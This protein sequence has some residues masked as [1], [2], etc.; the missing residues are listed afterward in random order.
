M[1]R[2]ASLRTCL[3]L[4]MRGRIVFAYV[5]MLVCSVGIVVTILPS[6]YTRVFVAKLN[7]TSFANASLCNTP[8]QRDS[9][10][11]RE[12]SALAGSWSGYTSGGSA[13]VT[14][15]LAPL[16]GQM[17]D[18]Y[19][20]RR[21][22]VAG[23]VLALLPYLV[24]GLGINVFHFNAL[25][26]VY[27]NYSLQIIGGGVSN[28]NLA[29]ALMWI[30][31]NFEKAQRAPAFAII[32]ASVDLVLA[33][34]PILGVL[35]NRIS[36][37]APWYMNAL[38]FVLAVMLAV[39][40]PDSPRFRPI[41]V[42]KENIGR[43][44]SKPKRR[45]NDN[46][47]AMENVVEPLLSE[48]CELRSPESQRRFLEAREKMDACWSCQDCR[49]V[50]PFQSLSI[51]N[52][53]VFFRRL[54]T[55]S[56]FNSFVNS[57]LQSI[58]FYML[59]SAL[60]MSSI[61]ISTILAIQA[62]CGFL[63]QAFLVRPLIRCVGLRRLVQFGSFC[64]I[65]LC[66]GVAAILVFIGRGTCLVPL[67]KSG[68]AFLSSLRNGTQIGRSD[69]LEM[70]GAHWMPDLTNRQALFL[71]TINMSVF[72]SLSY[73]VFPGISALK[74]N[75]VG[76][77]EQGGTLGA[78]WAIKAVASALAPLIFGA[79]WRIYSSSAPWL[80]YAVASGM[81]LCGF[82]VALFVPEPEPEPEPEHGPEPMHESNC[83]P[84]T[85]A[86]E[87]GDATIIHEA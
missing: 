81:A 69:C 30:S 5:T 34:T 80:V 6:V 49:S 82:A 62:T 66:V 41:E 14:F 33:A 84:K 24:L 47:V 65:F 59:I 86:F 31:D 79:L 38:C 39:Y 61:Q 64:L 53:S 36:A 7:Q 83:M 21:F 26:T 28:F 37:A 20:R 45:V 8:S 23:C 1:P 10:I 18:V 3:P 48:Q 43:M 11:C 9:K 12:A 71:Y 87:S 44:C 19:G 75:N 13:F 52:R 76:A 50:N 16:I 29:V 67:D 60:H 22:L 25:A 72:M 15:V 58:T 55:L 54:A 4:C 63:T 85:I 27:L 46:P 17:S 42:K 57:G 32:I 78:L 35:L 77:D 51:L 40:L 56:F 2:S 70:A 68:D 73:V 74:A